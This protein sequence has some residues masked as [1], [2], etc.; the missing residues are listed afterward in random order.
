MLGMFG[1]MT[2]SESQWLGGFR[3]QKSFRLLT[4]NFLWKMSYRKYLNGK[5]LHM[6]IWDETPI[7]EFRIVKWTENEEYPEYIVDKQAMKK[8]IVFYQEKLKEAWNKILERGE[9]WPATI[10][11]I[12]A[13]FSSLNDRQMLID[14]DSF[15]LQY[16]L[17]VDIYKSTNRR[18]KK[19]RITHW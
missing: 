18:K 1:W 4:F 9:V 11:C 10:Y 3:I 16:F 8:I 2:G 17:L 19:Y 15:L 6:E 7:K 12:K 14:S 5:N 13:Y